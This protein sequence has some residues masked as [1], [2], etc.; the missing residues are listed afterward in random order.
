MIFFSF[1]NVF[2][3]LSKRDVF[4]QP[5]IPEIT[6]SRPSGMATLSSFISLVLAVVSKVPAFSKSRVILKYLRTSLA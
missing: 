1:S 3:S 2:L 6:M 4:P 5:I